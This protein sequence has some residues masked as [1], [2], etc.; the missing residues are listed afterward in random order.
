[1]TTTFETLEKCY[2]R[3]VYE[4]VED[5]IDLGIIHWEQG[6]R[7]NYEKSRGMQ[8]CNPAPEPDLEADGDTTYFCDIC[9]NELDYEPSTKDAKIYSCKKCA[10]YE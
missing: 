7:L 8:F 3:E 6:A 2:D 5:A 9:G 1:M 4:T 10:I